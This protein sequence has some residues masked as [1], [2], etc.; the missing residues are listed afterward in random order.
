MRREGEVGRAKCWRH[1]RSRIRCAKENE[2]RHSGHSCDVSTCA[3][4]L[5]SCV[6]LSLQLCV[7]AVKSHRNA[8]SNCYLFL[9]F[10]FPPLFHLHG[11]GD[12]IQAREPFCS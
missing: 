10:H 3:L 8:P 12:Q 6:S 9:L 5:E 7:V 2:V 1:L 4:L 11:A